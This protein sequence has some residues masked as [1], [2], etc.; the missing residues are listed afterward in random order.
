[1]LRLMPHRLLIS[2]QWRMN[3]FATGLS[4]STGFSYFCIDR[5]Y[6]NTGKLSSFDAALS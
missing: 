6:R 3:C 1:M 2:P 5:I 4:G